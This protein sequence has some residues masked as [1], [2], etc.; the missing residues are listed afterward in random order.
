LNPLQRTG[1]FL[2][3]H[4][5]QNPTKRSFILSISTCSLST[6]SPIHSRP[7]QI[8]SPSTDRCCTIRKSAPR[9]ALPQR[10]IAPYKEILPR[11]R[12]RPSTQQRVTLF[13]SSV[14][15]LFIV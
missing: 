9:P 4:I 5:K 1:T 11:P 14:F 7:I 15:I 12:P 2:V 3:L 8:I 6:S 13:V 10:K